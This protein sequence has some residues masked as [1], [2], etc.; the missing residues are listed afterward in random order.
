MTYKNRVLT[1][2]TPQNGLLVHNT[3]FTGAE[4]R[5]GGG[6]KTGHENAEGMAGFCVCVQR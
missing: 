3:E 6:R 1:P 5:E 4:A 2:F